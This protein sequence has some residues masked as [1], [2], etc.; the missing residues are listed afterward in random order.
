MIR[1]SA[2][3]RSRS[4]APQ[5]GGPS[6]GGSPVSSVSAVAASRSRARRDLRRH[7]A[8]RARSAQVVSRRGRQPEVDDDDPARRGEDQV[9]RLDVAVHDRRVVAVKV[10]ERLGWLFE[11]VDRE[12]SL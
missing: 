4:I 3:I 5:L 1:S 9:G 8:G 10:L 2:G 6:V 11:V 12:R 7:V